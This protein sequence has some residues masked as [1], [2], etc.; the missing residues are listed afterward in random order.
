MKAKWQIQEAKNR[1][2]EVVERALNEGP[3]MVTRRGREAVMIV[4]VDTYRKLVG[5][6]KPLVQFFRE[7][8][9]CGVELE[10]ERSRDVGREV[11]L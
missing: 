5:R 8:P 6:K 4:A 2:S 10:L 3:Q 9:L 7:S 11:E 1:F